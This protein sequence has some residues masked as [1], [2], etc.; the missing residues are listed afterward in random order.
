MLTVHP[1]NFA[2]VVLGP[3]PILVALVPPHNIGT[4]QQPVYEGTPIHLV[5]ALAGVPL[6]ALIY[7]LAA[8]I[9]ISFVTRRRRVPTQ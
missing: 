3:V 5:V 8:Y 9:S 2:K 1:S 4:A 6:C 7:T